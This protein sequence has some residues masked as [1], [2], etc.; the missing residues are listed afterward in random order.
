MPRAIKYKF[1]KHGFTSKAAVKAHGAEIRKRYGYEV[2]IDD[3]DD[4][5]FLSELIAGHKEAETKIGVG[6]ARF[7][8]APPPDYPGECFWIERIDGV[9]TDFGVPACLD[10]IETINKASLRMSVSSQIED[11]RRRALNG[12]VDTFVSE[13]SGR[14]FPIAEADVDHVIPFD[15]LI[16]DFFENKDIDISTTML[17]QSVD[18]ASNPRWKSINLRNEF[19]EFHSKAHLRLVH[20]RENL[21]DIKK[22][23]RLTNH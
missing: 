20:R 10:D 6:I 4:I 23:K 14:E 8:V 22:E 17:T 19:L 15:T 3:Q 7:F 16:K 11:F 2:T 9:K 21:S 1:G 12:R 5:D 18:R 13:Y